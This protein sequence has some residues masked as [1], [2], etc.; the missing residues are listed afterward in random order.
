MDLS[1]H[2]SRL[3]NLWALAVN[4]Y[5]ICARLS[6]TKFIVSLTFFVCA[7]YFVV[8]TLSHMHT[9]GVA[10]MFGVIS[11][12]YLASLL[13]GSFLALCSLGV[14]VLAYDMHSRDENNHIN[15]VIAT[16]PVGDTLFFL[17]R[18]FGIFMLMG[19]PLVSVV[20]LSVVYGLISEIF[21]I[22]FGEP[23]EPWS[24]V[25]FLALDV[26]PNFVFYGSL[27]L[28]L[29][30]FIRPRFVALLVSVFCLYGWL[31]LTSRLPLTIAEPLHTVTGNV[32]FPSDLIP[33]LITSDIF[34]NRLALV[35]IGFGFLFWQ[36]VLYPRNPTIGIARRTRGADSAI[37]V[38]LLI[39]VMY[40]AHFLDDRQISNWKQIHDEHFDP[41]SFPDVH[42]VEGDVDIYPGRSIQLELTMS[43]SVSGDKI[44]EFALFSF[45]PGYRIDQLS[46][47]GKDVTDYQFRHGLLKIPRVRF[48]GEESTLKLSAKGQPKT[49]FAYLDS[50]DRVSS[51]FGPKVRQL[52]YLGTENYIFRSNFVVLMPG[53]KWYP[54][55]GTATNEDIGE[56]RPKDFFTIDLNVSVPRNWI[57]AG[58]AQR[59]LQPERKRTTYRFQTDNPVPQLAV[60]ASRF[61]QASQTIEG[62]EFEVLYK[63]VHRRTI[64]QLLPAG[65]LLLESVQESLDDIRTAGINYPFNVFSL[66]EVPA[67]LRVYGGGNKMD[68]VL[69]MPGVLMMPETTLPTMHLDSLHDSDDFYFKE[70][71]NLT[72]EQWMGDKAWPIYQY[73]GVEH[74]AGNHLSHFYRSIF[75][76]QTSAAGSNAEMLNLI[77]EQVV[78]LTFAEYEISFDFALAID[79]EI[80]D[81]SYI[82]P[83]HMLYIL[84]RALDI[85]RMGQLHELRE[86]RNRK[87][88]TD[89]VLA[90]VES[91][92]L[93][94]YDSTSAF[95]KVNHWARRTRAVAV[96]RVIFDVIGVDSFNL[97][98]A[99][100]LRRYRGQGFSYE[101]FVAVALS[102]GVDFETTVYDMMHSTGLPGFLVSSSSTKRIEADEEGNSRYQLTFVLENAEAVSG[103]CILM[104]IN[105]YSQERNTD[106]ALREQVFLE[107]NQ[108][109]QFVYEST[110]PFYSIMV[111]PYL[112]LN[113]TDLRFELMAIE[114]WVK[115]EE[116]YDGLPRLVSTDEVETESTDNEMS[117]V[118]DDLDS[119]FSIVD[120][121]GAMRFQPLTF[122]A[123]QFIGNSA[124]EKINGLPA[125]QFND[126]VVSN[127]TWE[128]AKHPSAFG[129]YWKTTT[130]NRKGGGETFAKFTT[131]LTKP[132]VWQLEYF[133]PSTVVERVRKFGNSTSISTIYLNRGTANL[134]IHA[135]SA[136]ITETID[137]AGLEIGW[138]TVG[139]YEIKN[140]DVE[141]WMSNKKDRGVVFADAVRWTPVDESE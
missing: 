43:V 62:I 11:P 83:T 18:L 65:T 19:I 50:V 124:N 45:N 49:Q 108:S 101:D 84:R 71:E 134:D 127:D 24:V 126:A 36:S 89:D 140:P 56:Q 27:V 31:W 54:V 30:S 118:I 42:R 120:P 97:V 48:T 64:E 95:D 99:E 109:I 40:G 103:H 98:L 76:D 123:R 111:E 114:D 85:S 55:A 82:E 130:M 110:A 14:L 77:L 133:L 106:F 5:R 107:R 105:D 34:L 51:I 60:V 93:A 115:E 137:T 69:G 116:L 41:V 25:S 44:G 67:S 128:R 68:T 53:I 37:G 73:F 29:A 38:V 100:L 35:I 88:S 78:E 112:S 129:K 102:Q 32:I 9:S 141:V 63:G 132:G 79:R 57:V 16:K 117:I 10:P 75:S 7:W 72:N 131:T 1:Q 39:A 74:Y 8:V 13:G 87:V 80:L 66:V 92:A 91:T 96:S 46:I 81:L 104:P 58:P 4:E 15:E 94:N 47:D 113:R 2:Q 22:P 138:H 28:F 139:E 6:R 70:R 135:D 12:R 17:G 121:R 61:K 26:I 33:T 59:K 90:V 20:V 119:G 52:R 125:F 3:S 86:S 122:L 136:V 23:I 21:A